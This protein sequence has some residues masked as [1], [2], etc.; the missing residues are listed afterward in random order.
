[1]C[2][3]AIL[4]HCAVHPFELLKLERII[5]GV[6]GRAGGEASHDKPAGIVE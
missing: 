5:A 1:V 4:H 3:H 2:H 6:D